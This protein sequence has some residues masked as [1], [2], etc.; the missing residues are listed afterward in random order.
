[1][2]IINPCQTFK[3]RNSEGGKSEKDFQEQC[4]RKKMNRSKINSTLLRSDPLIYLALLE[5]SVLGT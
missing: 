4:L 2:T 3:C 1:M 5:R